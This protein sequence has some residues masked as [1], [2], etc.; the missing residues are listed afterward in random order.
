MTGFKR[1]QRERDI[2]TTI[3]VEDS[4]KQEA[5]EEGESE[6]N[7]KAATTLPWFVC[8]LLAVENPLSLIF[9]VIT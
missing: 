2:L 4:Y 9:D 6:A 1:R 5:S 7:V 3:F 8:L